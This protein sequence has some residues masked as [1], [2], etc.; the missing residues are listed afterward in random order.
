MLFLTS[1]EHIWGQVPNRPEPPQLVNDL[2]ALF[3]AQ[4][5]AAFENTL[6]IFN[7]TTSNQIVIVTV[8]DLGMYTAAQ[9]AYEI[10]EQWGVGQQKFNNGVVILIKPKIGNSYGEA[11][12]ATGY[13]LEGVLPDATCTEIVNNEMIPYFRHND[14]YGGVKAALDVLLPIVAGEYSYKNYNRPNMTGLYIFIGLFA[15]FF[16][17]VIIAIIKGGNN[18]HMSSGRRGNG[19]LWKGILLGS[20]LSGGSR[21]SGSSWGGSSGGSFGGFGGGSFGGGGGGGRW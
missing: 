6:R 4:E 17:L 7:D 20:M 21:N 1:G 16:L 11:F 18:N 8:N 2:A 12:I 13:G 5:Q 19:D 14:Y 9:F 10:G 15:L 3:S